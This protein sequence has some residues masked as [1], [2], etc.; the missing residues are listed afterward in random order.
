MTKARV[1]FIKEH[2]MKLCEG[3]LV[4]ALLLDRLLYYSQQNEIMFDLIQEEIDLGTIP[5]F[6]YRH[7]KGWVRK[8]AAYLAESLLIGETDRTVQ[9]K[10]T[11]LADRD[12]IMRRRHGTGGAY[13]F[14]PNFRKVEE[15]LLKYN[16]DLEGNKLEEGESESFKQTPPT[17]SPPNQEHEKSQQQDWESIPGATPPDAP[18]PVLSPKEWHSWAAH[19]R[20][21]DHAP[22]DIR[23]AS[24]IVNKFTGFEPDNKKDW[25]AS[26]MALWQAA[27]QNEEV[28]KQA[29]ETGQKSRMNVENHFTFAGPRSYISFARDARA[30]ANLKQNGGSVV[31]VNAKGGSQNGVIKV[32]QHRSRMADTD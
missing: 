12:F 4:C 18:M 29:L 23:K 1:A 28:L 16:F 10:L 2:F 19:H 13:E 22:E 5:K 9:R 25:L 8:S 11:W 27:G 24:W 6:E 14:R 17:P 32:G 31:K 7:L 20:T 15:G 30:K 26:M 21:L 3:D